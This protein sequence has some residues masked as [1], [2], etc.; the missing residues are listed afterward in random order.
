MKTWSVFLL[1]SQTPSTFSMLSE[2]RLFL[3][4]KLWYILHWKS[5][6]LLWNLHKNRQHLTLAVFAWS[7]YYLRHII[8]IISSSINKWLWDQDSRNALPIRAY[9]RH[10]TVVWLQCLV[11]FWKT[12]QNERQI[13]AWSL[14]RKM[15]WYVKYYWK[16]V[17]ISTNIFVTLEM[18][19]S[20]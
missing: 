6:F 18:S 4:S 16:W 1:I 12:H 5:N 8:S 17:G 20:F 10:H 15:F 3:S 11:F 19:F 2:V 7:F 14:Q 13:R 9:Y